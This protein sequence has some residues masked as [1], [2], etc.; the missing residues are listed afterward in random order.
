MSL[1]GIQHVAFSSC[2]LPGPQPDTKVQGN[3]SK[4]SSLEGA[5]PV[6]F[7]PLFTEAEDMLP[8]LHT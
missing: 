3:A 4:L 6:L 8:Y 2:L 5:G 7:G 1:S